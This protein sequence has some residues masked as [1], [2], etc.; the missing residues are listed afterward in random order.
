MEN[1]SKLKIISGRAIL[2]KRIK[3][4][5][6]LDEELH[7]QIRKKFD[8]RRVKVSGIDEIWA[9]DLIDMQ[10]LSKQN[11]GIKYL[12]T[13]IDIFVNLFGLVL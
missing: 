8:R 10:A 13:V 12:L 5:N 7:K 4:A 6:V 11:K 9:A 1:S 2:L 3:F